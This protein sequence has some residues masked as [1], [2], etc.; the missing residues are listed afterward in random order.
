MTTL[1]NITARYI[2]DQISNIIEGAVESVAFEPADAH[3]V[4]WCRNAISIGMTHLRNQRI[5]SGY[6]I[7]LIL[8]ENNSIKGTVLYSPINHVRDVKLDFS[9]VADPS[10]AAKDH[11]DFDRAM[12]GI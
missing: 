10:K 9:L 5:I 7:D 4:E 2:N 11:L 8:T 12:K 1:E 6:T 3:T